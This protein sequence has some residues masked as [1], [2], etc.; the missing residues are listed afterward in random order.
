MCSRV[1]NICCAVMSAV[2]EAVLCCA[3]VL[4]TRIEPGAVPEVPRGSNPMTFGRWMEMKGIEA[5]GQRTSGTQGG[6]RMRRTFGLAS[7]LCAHFPHDFLAPAPAPRYASAQVLPCVAL[8][9]LC[10]SWGLDIHITQHGH[11][12]TPCHPTNIP[13]STTLPNTLPNTTASLSCSVSPL[14]PASQPP[15]LASWV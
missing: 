1:R 6:G 5:K 11:Y 10:C 8:A 4:F 15:P 3:G 14:H 13:T 9:S 7:K 2:T 12:H